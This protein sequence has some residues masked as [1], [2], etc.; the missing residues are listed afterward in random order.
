MI[1]Y[2]GRIDIMFGLADVAQ[3]VEQDFRKVKVGG[4]IPLI[5]LTYGEISRSIKKP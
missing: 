3:L 5:G 1:D 2:C 4:S